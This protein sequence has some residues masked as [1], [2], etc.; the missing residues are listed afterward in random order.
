MRKAER[1]FP[2]FFSLLL[3]SLTVAAPAHA[4]PV[5]STI[6]FHVIDDV[7]GNIPDPSTTY[8]Q[9]VRYTG[10]EFNVLFQPEYFGYQD[11]TA[12]LNWLQANF[13]GIPLMLDVWAGSGGPTPSLALST[14]QISQAL[15]VAN[16]QWLRISEIVAWYQ[17]NNQAFPTSYISGILSYAGAHNLKVFWSEWDE[18]A[19]AQVSS[20]IAGYGENVTVAFSTNSG[21]AYPVDGFKL[22]KN[23]FV[24][25]GASVQAWYW[26]TTTGED[27]SNMPVS[28]LIQHAQAA[29]NLGASVLQFEPYWYFFDNVTGAPN[30][31][32]Y[33]LLNA[34]MQ[35]GSGSD[36]SQ[37]VAQV[38]QMV[39]KFYPA[40]IAVALIGVCVGLVRRYTR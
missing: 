4:Q 1:C 30:G 18:H 6:V 35:G 16:V 26:T 9:I 7:Q 11:W 40:I 29:E 17:E 25:W 32:T 23:S 37:I 38:E 27:P 28:M 20:S 14:T 36:T 39:I 21:N 12:T 2:L 33:Q 3:L 8:N 13:S 19:F 10:G 34:I 22:V 31:K 5:L 24:H 15:A